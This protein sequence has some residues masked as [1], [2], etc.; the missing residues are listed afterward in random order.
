MKADEF[1]EACSAYSPRCGAIAQ[2]GEHRLCKPRV[3][4]SIPLCSTT[5]F[6][7]QA[8]TRIFHDEKSIAQCGTH[9]FGNYILILAH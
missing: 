9:A 5:S 8:N 2:L 3:R 1:S 7:S 4:G 6:L